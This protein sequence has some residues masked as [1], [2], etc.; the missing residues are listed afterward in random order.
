MRR[1]RDR[2]TPSHPAR[3]NYRYLS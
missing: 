1:R 2:I 3:L